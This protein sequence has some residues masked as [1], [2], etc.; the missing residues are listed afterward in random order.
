MALVVQRLSRLADAADRH[1]GV[2]RLQDHRHAARLQLLH[3][4]VGEL[5]GHALLHLRPARQHLDDAG[6]LLRPTIL[7]LGR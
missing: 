7:P 3:Q 2:R 4:Q 6:Q 1:A 5:L